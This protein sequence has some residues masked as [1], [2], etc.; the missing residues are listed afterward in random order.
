ML[1][2]PYT[3]TKAK[4]YVVLAYVLF[5]LQSC[6]SYRNVPYFQDLQKAGIDSTSGIN[7]D[8]VITIQAGDLLEINVTSLNP[9]AAAVFNYN[10]TARNEDDRFQPD[11]QANKG[12][13][14]NEAGSILMPLLGELK[15]KDLTTNE[16]T[17][18]LK[19]QLKTYLKEPTV[20]VRILNF[21]VSVL[22]DVKRPD[23]YTMRNERVSILE[24]M[25]MAG[26][27]NITAK[28]KD[29]LLV[30]EQG[31]QKQYVNIDLTSSKLFD[32]DYYYLKNNDVIYVNPSRAKYNEAGVAY[33]N[34]SLIMS[35]LSIIAIVATV[36]F[37]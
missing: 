31:G 13:R 6:G 26:D 19:E 29:V 37:R 5:F 3:S 1:K 32:S 20:N 16:L 8:G 9:E 22:G 17:T 25:S 23:V 33:R 28:R 7:G 15:V 12:I 27:L 34:A 11:L 35:G 4:H 24:A 14:V 30:R 10:F 2:T 36:I 21:R 18:T